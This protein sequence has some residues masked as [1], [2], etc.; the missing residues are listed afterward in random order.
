MLTEPPR[1]SWNQARQHRNDDAEADHV[2]QQRDEDEAH[3]RAN[4]VC[5]DALYLFCIARAISRP[6]LLVPTSINLLP[7]QLQRK[8]RISSSDD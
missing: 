7:E 1:Q 3:T 6:G 4:F 5:M 2:D 8:T